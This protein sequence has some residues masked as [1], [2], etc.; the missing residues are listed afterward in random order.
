MDTYKVSASKKLWDSSGGHG[1]GPEFMGIRSHVQADSWQTAVFKTLVYMDHEWAFMLDGE[2]IEVEHAGEVHRY[3]FGVNPRF[4]SY[5]GDFVHDGIPMRGEL[6]IID[7]EGD[8]DLLPFCDRALD[9]Y[10]GDSDD[11]LE[12]P[13]SPN[14]PDCVIRDALDFFAG[15]IREYRNLPRD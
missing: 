3:T 9:I 13:I 12:F 5:I 7:A 4:E 6:R 10:D 8:E 15:Q 11:F 1:C 14:M 2:W